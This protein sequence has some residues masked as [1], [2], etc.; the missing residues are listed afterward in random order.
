MK[1][2]I[3]A[4]LVVGIY[5]GYQ[6][7]IGGVFKEYQDCYDTA[8][9]ELASQDIPDN[10]RCVVAKLEY[11][12]M[13]SCVQNIQQASNLVGFLYQ[14]SPARKEIEKDLETHNDECK[15]NKVKAPQEAFYISSGTSR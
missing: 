10:Q 11:D 14:G 4:V 1:I 6:F 2:V 9:L 13:V 8:A 7:T 5:F 3:W 12:D 15:L